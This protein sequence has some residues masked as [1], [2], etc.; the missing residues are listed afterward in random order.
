M[1]NSS[2]VISTTFSYFQS[3]EIY[4]FDAS[5]S[6]LW[7]NLYNYLQKIDDKSIIPWLRNPW[8]GKDKQESLLRLFA[9][10][11]LIEQLKAYSI[12]KGNFN[13]K[14][15]TKHTSLKDVFYKENNDP[16]YLKDTGDKSDLTMFDNKNEKIILA[17]SSKNRDNEKSIKVNQGVL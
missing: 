4:R 14:T 7:I 6:F 1:G 12:C 15:I 2:D 13:L 3:I 17:T 8:Q 5:F 10:L 9:G 11:G 16:I